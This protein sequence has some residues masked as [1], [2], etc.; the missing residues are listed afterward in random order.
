MGDTMISILWKRSVLLLFV[1][2]NLASPGVGGASFIVFSTGGDNTTASIQTTVDAFRTDLGNPNNGNAAGPLSSGRREINWDGGGAATTVSGTP[3]TGFGNIRGAVF[4]TPGTGFVQAPLSGLA[5]TFGNPTYATIFS[6][7]SLLRLF[8][9]IGSN[10]T[11]VSFFVPGTNTALPATVSGFGAVF[12]DVDVGSSTR[13]QFFDIANNELFN[14]NVLPGTVPDG[15][16][17]FLGATANAGERIFRVRI[18]SGDTALGPDDNPGGGV[19]I[20]AMDDFLYAEL[21]AIPEPSSLVLLGSG[22][23]GLGGMA[24]RRHRR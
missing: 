18:T 3:F 16:L 1:V 2:F 11:D 10:I 7:F 20:V 24:W 8:T 4:A 14:D 22:L 9:P 12:T 5:A 15:S 6:P 17:S 13:I 23:V 21:Q 19:D